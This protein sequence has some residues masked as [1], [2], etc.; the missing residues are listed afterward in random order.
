MTI[1]T[2]RGAATALAAAFLLGTL[3]FLFLK[4]ASIDFKADASALGLL[5]E[6]RDLDSHWDGDAVRLTNDF[7]SSQTRAD[8]G[9]L[10]GRIVQELERSDR[11]TLARDLAQ[12]R[13]G[14]AE[15][16][17]AFKALREAHART[18]VAARTLEESL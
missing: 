17:A 7:T 15:K 13:T 4:S 9:A 16:D 11:D 12:L 18:V 6:M 2:K 8:F 1:K 14:L 3:I 10:M 5:R